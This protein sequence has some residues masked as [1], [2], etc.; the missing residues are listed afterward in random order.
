MQPFENIYYNINKS[1]YV[2]NILGWK[3]TKIGYWESYWTRCSILSSYLMP[4]ISLFFYKKICKIVKQI[5]NGYNVEE[6]GV[7]I[8]RN[9]L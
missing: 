6:L 7:S 1:N 5:M 8:D 4:I 2:L 9:A 3:Y